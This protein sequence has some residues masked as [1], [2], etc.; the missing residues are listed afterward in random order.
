MD[1]QKKNI[2]KENNNLTTASTPTGNNAGLIL[3]KVVAP[4]GD[5]WRSE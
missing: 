4:A 1:Y 2:F 5:A 3:I